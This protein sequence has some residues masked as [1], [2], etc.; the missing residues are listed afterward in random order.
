M[1][2]I[3]ASMLVLALVSAAGTVVSRAAGFQTSVST[4]QVTKAD[5][6]R[7]KKEL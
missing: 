3:A 2:T 4:H 7:W 5:V 1:R 6:E